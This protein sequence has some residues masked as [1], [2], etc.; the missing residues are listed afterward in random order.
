MAFRKDLELCKWLFIRVY[1]GHIGVVTSCRQQDAL[2]RLSNSAVP[3]DEAASLIARL[4][5]KYPLN[6][7]E[8]RGL[9]PV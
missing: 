6:L 1:S 5:T 3:G 9:W 8:C 7:K 2:K 4:R